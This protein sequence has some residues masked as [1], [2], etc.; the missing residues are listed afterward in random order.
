MSSVSK[1]AEPV[2]GAPAAVYVITG[3]DVRRSGQ[4]TLPEIL[5][6][7][8][9]LHVGR[10]DAGDYAI[11]ARGFNSSV[12]NKLLVMIDGRTVYTPLYSGVFW[13]VQ[14][15]PPADI[16]RIEV[17]S[18]PG[19]AL[20]GSNAVNGVINVVTRPAA[21]EGAMLRLSGG[22]ND[23][24][25]TAQ[26][27]TALGGNGAV[28]VYGTASKQG[29][30]LT[31]TG[32]SGLD[33][34]RLYQTGARADWALERG[35]LTLQGDYYDGVN[36]PSGTATVDTDG[37]NVLGRW[38]QEVGDSGAF[39]VQGYFDHAARSVKG[40]LRD[41]VNTYDI[42]AQHSFGIG[43]AQRFVVGGGYRASDDTLMPTATSS[44]LVPD[45]R[46][47]HLANAFV[48]DTIALTGAVK[49]AL[50]LKLESNS[51]TGIEYMPDARLSWQATP[52]T[53]LWTA[54]SRAVRTPSRFD[55]D[56]YNRGILNGGPGFQSETLI[57]YEA[58]YRA[59]PMS[60]ATLSVSVFYNDYDRLRTVE[61]PFP[62]VIMNNMYGHAYGVEAWA[63]YEPTDWWR[64]KASAT[65]LHKVLRVE[66]GHTSFFGVQQEGNDPGHQFQLRSE[67][68]L[69]HNVEIDAALRAVGS[70]PNPRVPAYAAL[71][72]R[73]GWNV[74]EHV[75]LSISGYNLTNASHTEFIVSSPPRRDIRRSVY[76]TARWSL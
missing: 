13:D 16:E 26:Y 58:G 55:R 40:G 21:D 69:A 4:S 37:G 70:L 3:A 64:L 39:E 68:N 57:A 62:L 28:R 54:V 48:H 31:P 32:A 65:A 75:Q 63:A 6:L 34:W 44:F 15:V 8:P 67:M 17:V 29:D 53:V 49:L 25:G 30:T 23:L 47:L 24:G 5:R 71:D 50:G 1:T 11:S 73:L 10:I 42:S 43:S 52:T 76:A 27:S 56:L 22:G 51:Y 46:M 12:S 66:P 41:S 45:S 2:S 36:K 59:R 61:P 9:N 19:G 60:N 33:S 18:G 72:A 14:N 74:S 20:W 7:A 35:T 38:R